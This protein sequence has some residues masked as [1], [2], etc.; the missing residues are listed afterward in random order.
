M[1]VQTTSTNGS[2]TPDVQ[3]N[4][5]V[6]SDQNV[7]DSTN[8]TITVHCCHSYNGTMQTINDVVMCLSSA[9]DS[10]WS[11]CT[12]QALVDLNTPSNPPLGYQCGFTKPS[13]TS[14]VKGAVGLTL[15]ASFALSLIV[16]L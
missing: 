8:N 10:V 12:A 16:A 15:L 5:T 4:G 11:T 6:A 3:W 14:H 13:A 7:C 9:N 1:P 2:V